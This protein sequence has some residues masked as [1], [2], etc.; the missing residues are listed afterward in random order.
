MTARCNTSGVC[1]ALEDEGLLGYGQ[2]ADGTYGDRDHD[3]A[4]LLQHVV[5]NPAGTLRTHLTHHVLKGVD[6]TD[7]HGLYDLSGDEWERHDFALDSLTVRGDDVALDGS[8]ADY[9]F[10]RRETEKWQDAGIVEL[11]DSPA[12]TRVTPTLKA[13]DLISEGIS[14]TT[15]ANTK[16][17][18]DR[19]WCQIMLKSVRRGDKQL[20]E[21]QKDTLANSLR[22]YI[23]RIEDYRLVFDVEMQGF[24][25]GGTDRMTKEYATR[26][27]HGGRQNK[28]FARLQQSLETGYADAETAVFTTLTSDPKQFD[29]L[30]GMIDNINENFNRLRNYFSRDPTTKADTRSED[31]PGWQKHRHNDVTGRPRENLD[32][33]KVL[34]FTEAGYPHLHVLFLDPPRREKDGCPWLIDKKELSHVWRQGEI[35]DVYPL[36][37]R[38]DLDQLG[39]FGETVVHDADGEVVYTDERGVET[40]A[41][42]PEATPKKRPVSE[43]FVC[44]YNYGDHNHGDEWAEEQ[45]RYHK[46]QGLIDMEGSDEVL[47]QKTAGSYIGK[48]LSKMYETLQKGPEP[49]GDDGYQHNGDAAWWK[50]AMYWATGRQ[51]WSISNG[52]RDAIRLEEPEP[53]PLPPKVARAVHTAALDTVDRCCSTEEDYQELPDLETPEAER[54][55]LAKRLRGTV[56]NITYL[57]TYRYDDLPPKNLMT[58]D[59]DDLIRVSYDT[60]DVVIDRGDRPPPTADL[61][62]A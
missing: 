57:G 27:S 32:Y 23:D 42:D 47:Q 49:T 12:G 29:S 55:R 38:D 18:H 25:D 19:E 48:Y 14:K 39:N 33:I 20:S 13:V 7:Y 21:A 15:G 26:F 8:D 45:T 4:H 5:H 54:D 58:H 44:W 16:A 59:L 53:D 52:I 22:R 3:R 17:V 31:T 9:Q 11:E 24:R 37:Y 60:P 56:A 46:E 40:D 61:Y 2:R 10:C 50:L 1:T 43:G 36:V 41:D 28:A 34:E 30:Y 62:A 35:V 51:F 6:P